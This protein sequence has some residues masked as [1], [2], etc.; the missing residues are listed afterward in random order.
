MRQLSPCAR[1]IYLT[2]ALKGSF[3]PCAD[4]LRPKAGTIKAQHFRVAALSCLVIR[5]ALGEGAVWLLSPGLL[6]SV[7]EDR[8]KSPGQIAL[9]AGGVGVVLP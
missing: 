4:T 7:V 9:L 3:S 2:F 1:L 6:V 8:N 5:E